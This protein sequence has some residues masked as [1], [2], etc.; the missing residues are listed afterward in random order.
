MKTL[1]ILACAGLAAGC[2]MNDPPEA[3]ADDEAKLATELRD[4]EQRGDAVSCVSTTQLR[5]NR[6]AGEGAIIFEGLGANLW[7]NRPPGGCPDLRKHLALR[8]RTTGTQLC[9]GD[10]ALVFDPGSGMSYGGCAL[11]EFTPYRRVKR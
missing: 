6:S 9:R 5:G 10:I 1:L 3:S 11:G 7:V 4:Y 8:T 2:T